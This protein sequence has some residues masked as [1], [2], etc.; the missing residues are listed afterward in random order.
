M[1]LDEEGEPEG[2]SFFA[3]ASAT[4]IGQGWFKLGLGDDIGNLWALFH[5]LDDP[6]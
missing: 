2:A 1:R 3:P 6:A 5:N 4:Q